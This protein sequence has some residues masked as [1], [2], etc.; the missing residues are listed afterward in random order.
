MLNESYQV[1]TLAEHLSKALTTDKRNDGSEFVHLKEN[2][3]QWMTE[4]I[5]SVHGEKL[6][7]DVT[8]AFISE[9]ADAIAEADDADDAITEIEP[10]TYT[11]DL[12]EWLH[13]RAD[14]LYYVTEVLEESEIKDG[15][16]LLAAAQQKQIHEIG[17]A[18]ISALENVEVLS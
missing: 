14:H 16:Q 18:L 10:D 6:P 5:R 15:F 8:Y 11:H 13:S 4:V 2:S 3:P 12:T 17:F 9:C 7:D 1:R